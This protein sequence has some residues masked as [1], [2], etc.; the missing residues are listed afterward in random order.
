VAG[1]FLYKLAVFLLP[2]LAIDSSW[3]R[4]SKPVLADMKRHL[5]S[6]RLVHF[7][8]V[9]YVATVCLRRDS[10]VM[11]WA[12]AKPLLLS[13]RHSLEIFSMTVVLDMIVNI[14]VVSLQ[15]PVTERLLFDGLALAVITIIAFALARG[16]ASAN[17]PAQ[18]RLKAHRN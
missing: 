9:A 13:G 10:P 3:L 11:R 16:A 18:H 1:A 17:G 15:P 7:L 6:L 4:F 8:C 2:H 12:A 14:A 5:S